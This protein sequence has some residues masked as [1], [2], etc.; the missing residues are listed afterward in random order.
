M[1]PSTLENTKTE[2]GI[3][4]ALSAEAAQAEVITGDRQPILITREGQKI[5][6]LENQLATPLRIKGTNP[7]FYSLRDL[8]TYLVG[9]IGTEANPVVF[10]DRKTL[11][12]VAF[13]DYHHQGAGAGDITESFNRWLDHTASLQYE[14][15]LQFRKWKEKDGFKFTQTAFAEFLEDNLADIVSPSGSE[16]LSFAATLEATSTEVF[17]SAVKLTTGETKFT[18]TNERTGDQDTKIIDEFTLGIPLWERGEKVQITAKLMHRLETVK[19]TDS[20]QVRFWF[21]LRQLDA[22]IDTLWAEDIGFLRTALKDI[23]PVYEGIPPVKP[24]NLGFTNS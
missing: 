19:D 5:T 9:Q 4:A 22:I 12:F 7:R 6:S 2:A 3:I 8:Q 16:V 17:K 11:A 21:K 15:S 20:K 23:A 14:H 1:Q 13:L 18:F 24:T 10:A